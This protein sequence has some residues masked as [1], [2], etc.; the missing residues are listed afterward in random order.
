M[1]TVVI[2]FHRTFLFTFFYFHYFNPGIITVSEHFARTALITFGIITIR[3]QRN[4]NLIF[5]FF[6]FSFLPD[7]RRNF[8]EFKVELYLTFILFNKVIVGYKSDRS[9][10]GTSYIS[11]ESLNIPQQ[12]ILSI[13]PLYSLV[14]VYPTVLSSYVFAANAVTM[15]MGVQHILTLAGNHKKVP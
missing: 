1:R 15:A 9:F 4:C 5:P 13:H 11:F 14:L 3:Y 2:E 10:P 6:I 12:K 8:Y 7:V